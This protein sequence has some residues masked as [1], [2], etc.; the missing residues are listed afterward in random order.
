MRTALKTVMIGCAAMLSVSCSSVIRKPDITDLCA[1]V[2][3]PAHFDHKI[4]QVHGIIRSDGIEHTVLVDGSC[5]HKGVALS[6]SDEVASHTDAKALLDAIYRE[7]PIGT[8]GK[9]IAAT[10]TGVF[11]SSPGGRPPR[12]LFVKSVSDLKVSRQQ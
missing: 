8:A 5:D 11:L 3:Q 4:V 12:T 10:I 1:L 6:I 7:G 2:A 9:H